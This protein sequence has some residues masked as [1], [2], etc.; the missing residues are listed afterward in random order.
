MYNCWIHPRE[1]TDATTVITDLSH[2]NTNP[3][4]EFRRLNAY[5]KDHYL[6]QAT[7]FNPTS[8]F[9][10]NVSENIKNKEAK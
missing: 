3:H 7:A 6:Y 8:A 2:K 5:P 1:L 9:Y 4:M 10:K